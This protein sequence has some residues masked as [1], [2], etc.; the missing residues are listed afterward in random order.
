MT[1]LSKFLVPLAVFLLAGYANTFL[2]L[3][4]VAGNQF[5]WIIWFD[6]KKVTIK[7][8]NQIE[9][10]PMIKQ[11]L[12]FNIHLLPTPLTC[13]RQSI[14]STT[15]IRLRQSMMSTP[16]IP[17]R[18]SMVWITITINFEGT[19]EWRSVTS[20]MMRSRARVLLSVIL[21]QKEVRHIHAWFS[22]HLS[23]LLTRN[24]S[25]RFTLIRSL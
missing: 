24:W 13:L 20:R 17:L 9:S 15:F 19:T 1:A 23:V 10:Q 6:L 5:K 14:A 22:F 11:Q 16:F 3:S 7:I 18:Q 2:S 21:D 8:A 25:V 4:Q 12:K